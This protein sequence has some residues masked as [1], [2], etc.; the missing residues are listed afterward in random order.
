MKD[1]SESIEDNTHAVKEANVFVCYKEQKDL[2]KDN[3]NNK[4][5]I[6]ILCKSR[7]S[8]G[9]NTTKND[10]EITT[11][12]MVNNISFTCYE[13]ICGQIVVL[14][15]TKI[16]F[17]I[18]LGIHQSDQ[19]YQSIDYVYALPI[20]IYLYFLFGIWINPKFELF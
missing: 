11:I 2:K 3:E 14:A 6:F 15:G 19:G 1:R 20:K 18:N 16:I 4:R 7:S 8:F 10:I 13:G 12:S 17:D 5:E 9:A